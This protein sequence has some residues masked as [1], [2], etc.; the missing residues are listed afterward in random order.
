[1]EQ[2]EYL[3]L[4][5]KPK[6]QRSFST[7]PS[8]DAFKR[9]LLNNDFKTVQESLPHSLPIALDRQYALFCYDTDAAIKKLLLEHILKYWFLEIAKD[10]S[11]ATQ[12]FLFDIERL[13]GSQITRVEEIDAEFCKMLVL[14][15]NALLACSILSNPV[16]REQIESLFS[17]NHLSLKERI[18]YSLASYNHDRHQYGGKLPQELEEEIARFRP[19]QIQWQPLCYKKNQE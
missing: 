6:L 11:E 2:R 5:K 7:S 16:L 4:E 8:V 13:K 3:H 18:A 15:K 19:A 1:M 14:V 9:A 10:P 12:S 17:M